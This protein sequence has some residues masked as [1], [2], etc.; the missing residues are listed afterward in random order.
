MQDVWV[1]RSLWHGISDAGLME[2]NNIDNSKNIPF[3]MGRFPVGKKR[4]SL[5]GSYSAIRLSHE[6][7]TLYC[8]DLLRGGGRIISYFL[9]FSYIIK[10]MNR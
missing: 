9:C 4:G 7:T 3:G 2:F 10:S 5:D 6:M 1:V 8:L